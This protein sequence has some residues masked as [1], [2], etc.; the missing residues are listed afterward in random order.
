MPSF[1]KFGKFGEMLSAHKKTINTNKN[2]PQSV[3]LEYYGHINIIIA[4]YFGVLWG[5]NSGG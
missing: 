3:N 2:K 4:F 1:P 5:I